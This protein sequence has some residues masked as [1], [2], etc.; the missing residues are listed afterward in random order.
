M[1]IGLVRRLLD[2]RTGARGESL[3]EAASR[4]LRALTAVPARPGLLLDA[5][6]L[7]SSFALS[8]LPWWSPQRESGPAPPQ[9]ELLI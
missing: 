1:E 3:Q 2:G 7:G 5:Y 9:Q 8:L 4:L 6:A